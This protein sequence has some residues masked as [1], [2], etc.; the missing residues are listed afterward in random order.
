MEA[1]ETEQTTLLTFGLTHTRPLSRKLNRIISY[2][3]TRE[4]SNFHD[5]GAMEKH[6]ATYSLTYAF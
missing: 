1:A 2:Q 3:Y 6:L 5:E 4:D